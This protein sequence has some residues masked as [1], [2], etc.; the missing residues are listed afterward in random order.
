MTDVM[1]EALERVRTWP[2]DRQREAAELLV[3]L[4]ELGFDPVEV[5]D[6]TLAAIDDALAQVARGDIADPLKVQDFFA[7]FRT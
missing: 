6:E 7:R 2:A 1:D 4:D 3:A 5:D